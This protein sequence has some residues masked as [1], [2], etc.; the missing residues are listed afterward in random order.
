M[1]TDGSADRGSF[2][3]SLSWIM[4]TSRTRFVLMAVAAIG[5]GLA[6]AGVLVLVV[7]LALGLAKG[8]SEVSL[9]VAG[10]E[11]TADQGTLFAGAAVLTLVMVA[12]NAVAAWMTAS[13]SSRVLSDLREGTFHDF[14]LATWDVQSREPEGRLQEIMS[15]NAMRVAA[16]SV[17]LSTA[18]TAIFNLLALLVAALVLQP[19]AALT[20]LGAVIVL[21]A[22]L[23]PVSS[24]ARRLSHR[25]AS[26]GIWYGS[27]ITENVRLAREI[28]LFGGERAFQQRVN[29]LS[30]EATAPF[31]RGRLLARMLPGLYQ[32]SAML[33]IVGALAIVSLTNATA[34]GTLGAVVLIL[35]RATS[36]S[37]NVQGAYHSINEYI[38]YIQQLKQYR[39]VY[40]RARRRYGS[41]RLG[42]IKNIALEDVGFS[43]VPGETALHGVNVCFS[44]GD[45]LGVVGPSGSGK[46]TLMQILLGLRDPTEGV[47]LVNGVPAPEYRRSD[48]CERVAFVPQEPRLFTDSIEENIRFFRDGI[49]H[50]DVVRVAQMAHIADEINALPRSYQTTMH[51]EGR[52]LSGGQRQRLAIARALVDRPDLLVLDEPTSALDMRSEHLLH[53]TL[54]ELKRRGVTL[55]IVAHRPS[56]IAVCDRVVVM[57][58]GR[59]EAYAPPRELAASNAYFSDAL[60]LSSMSGHAGA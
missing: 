33:L 60:R 29:R 6:E 4:G 26:A 38:P 58:R 32:G 57:S 3:D 45:A 25:G 39:S 56:T 19:I 1:P 55:V 37:N 16:A 23:R 52:D 11:L 40:R 59:V 31:F 12:L 46:S 7:Q 2:R 35:V 50:D 14:V 53:E 5:E 51:D 10:I 18:I 47:Y 9:S 36:Y 49:S 22:M 43:Y 17:Q 41:R 24:A 54:E 44:S 20:I 30:A 48:W 34:F 27:A 21:F 13:I 8:T 28:Q 15:T 42:P